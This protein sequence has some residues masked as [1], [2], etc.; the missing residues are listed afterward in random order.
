[1]IRRSNK[2]KKKIKKGVDFFCSFLIGGKMKEMYLR[3]MEFLIGEL[4]KEWENSG[5]ETEK[6]V[7]TK[8]E[9]NELKRKVMLN[10]VR[11]QD[12]I[13]NNQN[14]MFTESI[15]M[16][17]DNF[18]M[19][20]IIKKLLVEIKKETDFVTLNLDKDEYEKYTSLVKLKEGY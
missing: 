18:I 6:V 15:K 8:D 2:N 3:Y 17:K 9:A 4:H 7:L 11:Q 19:L 14:I 16:S 10:I 13:D 5:S 12:G 20:R 1:M